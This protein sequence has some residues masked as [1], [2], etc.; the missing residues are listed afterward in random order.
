MATVELTT[1]NFDEIAT[2]E[3]IVLLD[4]W[5][6][7]CVPCRMFGPVYERVSERHPDIVFGKVDTE[8][9]PELAS[10]FQISSVPTLFAVRDGIV[11]HARSGALPEAG[12]EDLVRRI[13]AV[14]MAAV[15]RQVAG[16]AA[17]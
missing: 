16:E 7:W 11:L 14:D 15:H 4:F 2:A 17:A 13:R 3:G 9:Q 8:A 5:A 12:L 1:D 10:D 6:G